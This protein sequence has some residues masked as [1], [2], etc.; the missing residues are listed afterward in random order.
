MPSTGMG[1]NP[2]PGEVQSQAPPSTDPPDR[3]STT[4]RLAAFVVLVFALEAVVF[5]APLGREVTPFALAVIPAA[6][7]I[8]VSA[9]TGGARAVRTL[10]LIHI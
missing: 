2:A 8:I 6:A 1:E 7:G 9:R 5:L 4:R 10:S 3:R